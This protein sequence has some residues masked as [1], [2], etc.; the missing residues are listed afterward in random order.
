MN[1]LE[2]VGVFSRVKHFREKANLTIYQLSMRAGFYSDN[3]NMAS[4]SISR[5]E[6]AEVARDQ[7]QANSGF[8][9]NPNVVN[10]QATSIN[11][12]AAMKIFKVL[13]NA[14]VVNN[15]EEVFEIRNF[16]VEKNVQTFHNLKK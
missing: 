15:F 14:G 6:A 3:G 10:D 8:A 2:Q 5:L 13:Q 16:D 9:E 4:R 11:L 7:Q 12:T 1:N